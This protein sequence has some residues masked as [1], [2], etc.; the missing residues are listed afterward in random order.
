VRADPGRTHQ[1]EQRVVK[2]PVQFSYTRLASSGQQSRCPTCSPQ[3]GLQHIP[4]GIAEQVKPQYSE[5]D[6]Q[7]GEDTRPRRRVICPCAA[8]VSMPPQLGTSGG[9][10]TPRKLR[11]ASMMMAKP[12]ARPQARERAG[13]RHERSNCLGCQG[14][15]YVF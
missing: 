2:K 4:Q 13:A 6:G 14:A 5:E 8:A 12:N 9:T 1:R 15:L 11:E 10:P 3:P 7:A